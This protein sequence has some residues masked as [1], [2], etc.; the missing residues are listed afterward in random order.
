MRKNGN[1][2]I[3]DARVV[4]EVEKPNTDKSVVRVRVVFTRDGQKFVDVRN[5]Y[6][7]G[8]EEGHHNMG[9]GIWLDM[10]R[11]VLE[12]VRDSIDEVLNTMVARKEVV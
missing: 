8:Y 3:E 6:N 1:W 10:D 7:K 11:E 12:S 5:W 9:K 4:T 2:G